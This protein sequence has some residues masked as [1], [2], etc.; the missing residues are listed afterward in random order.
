MNR[1]V[2][3]RVEG[4]LLDK[5]VQRA[6]AEGAVFGRI[7]RLDARHMLIEA[8]SRSAQILT[9]LC[10]RFGYNCREEARGGITA[11]A[12]G[13]RRRWTLFLGAALGIAICLLALSR[14]WLI[15]IIFTGENATAG[16]RGEIL[17]CLEANGVHAGMS[18]GE[19]DADLLQ[20]QILAQ[21]S[22]LSYAGVRLQG[23]RLL[24]EATPQLD[25]PQ[26]YEIGYARDLV[27]LANGVVEQVDVFSGQA[28]VKAGDTVL[29]GDTL[30]RGEETIGKN[31]QTGEITTAPVGARG[32]VLARCWVEGSASAP[33]R[34][35]V[36]R[37]TGNQRT[38]ARLAVPGISFPLLECEAYPSEETETEILPVVGLFLPVQMERS[39]H[40]ETSLDVFQADPA[41]LEAQLTLLARSDALRKIRQDIQEYEIT[42]SWVEA[43]QNG[44]TLQIRAVYEICTDIAAERD[45]LIEEVY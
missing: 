26:L 7:R 21:D 3:L 20:K 43:E 30:I 16:N 33:L 24:V 29:R 38:S 15:D 22:S 17:S 10:R 18:L 44:D 25:A 11:L 35:S 28:C 31:T 37:R 2:R 42:A 1:D 14:L 27:S 9:Q 19:I 23:I 12:E 8:D 32:R 45:A 41:V 13:L 4:S 6:L 5:L 36:Q 34:T 40:Y 39:I